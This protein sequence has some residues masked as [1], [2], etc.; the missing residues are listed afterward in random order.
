MLRPAN[1]N[2]ARDRLFEL[3]LEPPPIRADAQLGG[4]ATARLSI[5]ARRADWSTAAAAACC[6]DRQSRGAFAS[7]RG[8]GR[9]HPDAPQRSVLAM[10][11]LNGCVLRGPA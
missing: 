2:V 5:F 4:A 7:R 3:Q 1:P 6:R 10:L 9:E 8:R 11:I